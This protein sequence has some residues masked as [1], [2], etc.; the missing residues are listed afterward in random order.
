MEK[1]QRV[2]GQRLVA[3]FIVGCLLFNYPLLQLF[4]VNNI[5]GGIPVL[6]IY[7]F[8][9]WLALIILMALIIERRDKK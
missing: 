8:T 6:Y 9:A 7:V 1:Q 5:I 4:S 3:I 2:R